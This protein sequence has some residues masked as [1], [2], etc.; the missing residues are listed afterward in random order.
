MSLWDYDNLMK[1]RHGVPTWR[2]REKVIGAL[3]LV[4]GL[5]WR[6]FR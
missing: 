6:L 2:L 4:A 3:L 5:L 1:W